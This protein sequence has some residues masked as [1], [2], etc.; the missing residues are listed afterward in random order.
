M[1]NELVGALSS[2]QRAMPVVLAWATWLYRLSSEES[3]KSRK[4]ARMLPT[5]N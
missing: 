3:V 5:L 4:C 1:M 2:Q